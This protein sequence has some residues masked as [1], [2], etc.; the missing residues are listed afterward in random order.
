M[1]N[2]PHQSASRAMSFSPSRSFRQWRFIKDTI[3]RWGVGFGGISVILAIILIF[4]YLLYVVLPLF[5][6]AS[7]EKVAAYELPGS[8]APTLHLALEE[9]REIGLRVSADGDLNYFAAKTGKLIKQVSLDLP[10]GAEITAFAAGEPSQARLAF[11]LSDGSLV[12]ARH[13]Y[14]AS[15]PNDV[16]VLTPDVE[17]PLGA[18]PLEI[19]E[20]GKALTRLAFQDGEEE[21]TVAAETEDGRLLLIHFAKEA[22]MFGDE[23]SLERTEVALPIPE[24]EIQHLLLDKEQRNLYVTTSDGDLTHFDVSDKEDPQVAERL[25][26]VDVGQTISSIRFLTGDISLLVSDSSGRIVQWFSVRDELGNRGLKPIREFHQQNSSISD[27][28]PE[29]HRKGFLAADQTGRVGI[30]HSTAEHLVLMQQIA[31]SPL[32][33]LAISSHADGMLA[34]DVSGNLSFWNIDNEHPEI[35]WSSL[36]EKVW[37]ESYDEPTYA[38]QSSS[39]SNDFEPKL[40]L[41]PLVFGTIKAAFYAMLLAVPIA[42]MGA[43]YTAYF[44]APSLRKVVK[45]SIETMEA[46]PTVI[47]GF[48]AGL[49]LAPIVEANL[50]A[51]FS[52]LI[53][54]PFGVLVFAYMWNHAPASIRHSLPE[55]WDAALLIPV[56]LVLSWL[57]FAISGPLEHWLFAGSMQAWLKHEFGIGFDQRNSIVVGLAMGFAVIPTI[58]SITEDAI[59]SVPKHLTYGS[60]AL[61]ATTWQTLTRVVIL[62]ASPGIFSAVMIGMGR[63]VGETMIVLMATGNTPVMDFSIFQGMRTLSANIAV[64][65]PESE[66]NSTHYRVLFLAALVLFLFTFLFNT[67]AEL[68]RQRLRK[69]YSSL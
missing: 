40:S 55:G 18:E 15:Y 5:E 31:Q 20:E 62:T 56:V 66:V 21:A 14:R 43:I 38:W 1:S 22:S 26:I 8:A 34:Q 37:Y 25:H 4:F 13:I 52:L 30:Y 36:W 50:L 64:E 69:K 19:D 59:F 42:I 39:A 16:R 32:S 46:L 28:A 24:G 23:V 11:G 58:F 68:I 60:L 48:L 29:F 61:G 27:L 10:E 53:V 41:T 51:I 45:P 65:M 3:A 67:V 63:A 6:P 7:L 49:W 12:V 33:H 17:Y 9:Q 57:T 35:S 47:L 44:M 2:T 54:V